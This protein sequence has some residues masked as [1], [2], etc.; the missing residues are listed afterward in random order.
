MSTETPNTVHGRLLEAVHISGY[1]FDRACSELE[2]LLDDDRWKTVGSGFDDINGFL[3]TID[4]SEFRI[5]VEQRQKLAKRLKGIE[6]SQR[7]TAR[8]LG[9]GKTTIVRDLNAGPNGPSGDETT[10]QNESSDNLA[11]PNGP[12][13]WFQSDVNPA[14]IAQKETK[15]AEKAASRQAAR[16]AYESRKEGGGT[17][18]SLEALAASG[19]RFNVIY[20]DPPWTFEV[21][22]GKGKERSAERHYDTLS[23]DAIKALPIESLAATDCALFLWGVWP[24][25]PGALDIIDAW[26]FKYKTLGLLW[27]KQNRSGE[28]VFTGMG[29]WT[30]ANSEPC[31]LATRGSP[32]RL[33]LDVHQVITSPVGKHS[34]KPDE[35][36][37]RI[38]RLLAGPYL[39][40]YARTLVPG[41]T[42]WGDEIVDEAA[43]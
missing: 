26:G 4:L 13:A 42:V 27:V 15:K 23:L 9:V 34:A 1:T 2:W 33:A 22:S 5:A 18:E 43:E 35:A 28:G 39:E 36:R 16:E 10:K 37:R 17:I 12:P 25:L 21:Y 8:M 7:A 41:W 32:Q 24:E 40:L 20:A 30:R 19:K 6:A 11:G 29:Y 38:E 31:L 3:A 14:E